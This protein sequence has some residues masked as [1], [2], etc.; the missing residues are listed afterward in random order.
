MFSIIKSLMSKDKEIIEDEMEREAF[1]SDKDTYYKVEKREILECGKK[2]IRDCVIENRIV[3]P[4]KYGFIHA[5]YIPN[6]INYVYLS[7]DNVKRNLHLIVNENR[8][9]QY[10]NN[11][12]YKYVDAVWKFIESYD[13]ARIMQK[14]Y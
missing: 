2:V 13:P 14:K 5:K 8:K 4:V 9:K 11:K 10:M 1:I 7:I 3:Y 6:A 12:K